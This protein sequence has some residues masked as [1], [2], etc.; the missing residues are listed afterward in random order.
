MTTL[1]KLLFALGVWTVAAAF[2]LFGT[3]VHAAGFA[4]EPTCYSWNG[5]HKSAGSFSKCTPELQAHVARPVPAPAPTA[6]VVPPPAP[7]AP[8]VMQSCPPPP[9]PKPYL[10]PKKPRPKPTHKC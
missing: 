1:H 4:D 2:V 9:A 5:G 8:V 3:Q 6:V 10:A 7:V